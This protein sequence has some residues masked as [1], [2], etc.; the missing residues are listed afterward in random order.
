MTDSTNGLTNTLQTVQTGDGDNSPLQLSLTQV[1][2]T[3]SLTV[4]G[5][6]ISVDTG[7]LVTTASF[8]AYTS[9]VNTHLAGLDVETGSLQNQINGLATTGS[10][11]FVGNQTITGSLYQSGTFY[12][13]QIDV[14][15]GGIVQGTGSYIATFKNDGILE[16]DTYQNVA[17]ELQQ[18]INTGSIPSGTV[19]GSAQIVELGFA[20][21]SSLTSLSSSIATTDL[22]QDNRLTALEGVTGSINRNGLISTG[23][24]GGVQSITGSLNVQGTITATSA[25]F[26]YINTVYET[27]SVIY[28]SGSNQFG[29][30]SNDTQTLWGTVKIPSG[31]VDITGSVKIAGATGTPLTVD[32]YDATPSQNTLIGFLDSGSAMWS[33]GNQGNNDS[34]I[35]YNPQ[36]FNVPLEI[37]QDNSAVLSGPMTASGF[38]GNL[39]GTASFA[40]NALSSSQAQNAISSSYATNAL[41]ASY[42]PDISNRNGLINTGSAASVQSIT[43]SLILS[44]S[45]GPELDIKGD[46]NISGSLSIFSGS[47]LNISN[48]TTVNINSY[49]T[50]SIAGQSNIIKGWSDNPA[51]GGAAVIQGNYTG[52]VTINGSNNTISMPQIRATGVGGSTD[53]TG[54][55][56]GSD[57][58]ITNN[59]GI[60]MN[61]GSLLFP[62]VQSNLIGPGG[63]IIMSFTSSSLGGLPPSINNNIIYGGTV[64]LQSNSGSIQGVSSNAILGGGI[65]S[66]QNFVTNTRPSIS[67][68]NVIGTVNLNHISSSINYGSNYNNSPIT[69]NNYSSSSFTLSSTNVTNNTFL[70]G[71]TGAGHTIFISGSMNSSQTRNIVSNLLGGKNLIVSSSAAGTTNSQHLVASIVYGQ[72]L[73]ISASHTATQGGAAFFG[74][75]NDTGSLSDAQNNVFVVGTGT[76]QTTRRNGLWV[77]N[78][79]VTNISGSLKVIG[80]TNAVSVTGSQTIQHSVAGQAALT[81]LA[82]SITQPAIIAT[83]SVSVSGSFSATGNI[84]FA[85]GSNTT[86]GNVMLNGGSPS[87]VTVANSLVASNSLIFLTKQTLSNSNAVSISAR[88]AGTFTITS[89]GNGDSDS[90]AY[91]IINPA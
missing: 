91:L 16:Y 28:S 66:T 57:N 8:N 5:Q 60:Y 1:N 10:N 47:L 11:V 32:H 35:V 34:F 70:G 77:D 4:N 12:A 45:A 72:G 21:T 37:K 61:T 62:R 79:S 25:S 71:D 33:I 85:S 81:V 76:N 53:M 89:T 78:T 17:S 38:F 36:T 55:I 43:G 88:S 26:T 69:I 75:F 65:F 54:Y 30:A 15:Q 31:P 2:I 86:M 46:Q 20:T 73:Y 59:A 64:S 49:L 7:S 74:R 68:C 42:A 27:A 40:T 44:G 56:S 52:S 24:L 83:G 51:A 18:Y 3:G 22:N 84:L 19:S 13:D 39:Q 58:V 90:V 29:D 50:S 63:G 6:P 87:S 67:S 9:S 80:V 41:S 48:G 14:S 82:Q 23:S